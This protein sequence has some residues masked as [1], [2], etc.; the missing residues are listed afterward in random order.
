MAH[1]Y[2]LGG[3]LTKDEDDNGKDSC[4]IPDS[5]AGEQA[6]GIGGHQGGDRD[7]DYIVTHQDGGYEYIMVLTQL[8]GHM[9]ATATLVL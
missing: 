6:D 5:T 3:Y 7:V 2:L 9:S 1:G 4:C 8:I